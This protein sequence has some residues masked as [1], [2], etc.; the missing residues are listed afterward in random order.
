[1]SAMMYCT[2]GYVNYI[3]MEVCHLS[4]RKDS[5]FDAAGVQDDVSSY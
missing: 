5:L 4:R 3:S 1:M 2:E